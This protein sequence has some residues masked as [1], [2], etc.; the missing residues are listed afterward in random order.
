MIS[1]N[2]VRCLTLAMV[3]ALALCIP[4]AI[5]YS[6]N[7]KSGQQADASSVSRKKGDPMS[8]VD[9][10]LGKK[11]SGTSMG[12]QKTDKDG[13]FTFENVPVGTYHLSFNA[14]KL[15]STMA[16]KVEYLVVIEQVQVGGGDA[17]T[18]KTYTESKSNTA[19]RI[20]V[21]KLKE[22]VDL[23]VGPQPQEGTI[24]TSK[25]NIKNSPMISGDQARRAVPQGMTI[26]GRIT[27]V[28]IGKDPKVIDE[29]GVK[30]QTKMP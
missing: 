2:I 23:T 18:Q 29:P 19:A 5:A 15:S 13:R 21:A 20:A 8:G 6:S 24:N 12:N 27:L 25:S 28:E 14:P 7:Q 3:V 26:Q 1:Q 17:S 30:R 22:G 16:G 9:V 10:S 4:L 11:P